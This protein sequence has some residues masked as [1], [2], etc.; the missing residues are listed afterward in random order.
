MHGVRLDCDGRN[1]ASSFPFLSVAL[2]QLVVK[3]TGRVHQTHALFHHIVPGIQLHA[4]VACHTNKCRLTSRRLTSD[5]TTEG[6]AADDVV[7]AKHLRS[8]RL[9]LVGLDKVPCRSRLGQRIGPATSAVLLVAD[10]RSCL[11][12]LGRNHRLAI[13]KTLRETAANCLEIVRVQELVQLRWIDFH[14]ERVQDRLVR[15]K[16]DGRI[17]TQGKPTTSRHD[18]LFI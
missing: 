1:G 13:L 11:G 4:S 5:W 14:R 2:R 8:L 17:V 3:R 7:D 18:C 15:G 9:R 10:R 6:A 16:L 12:P